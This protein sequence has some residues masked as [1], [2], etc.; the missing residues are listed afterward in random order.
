MNIGSPA[1]VS[2]S[3]VYAIETIGRGAAG[4]VY[5]VCWPSEFPLT[6]CGS[7]A[8]ESKASGIV[9]TQ[10]QDCEACARLVMGGMP[11]TRRNPH[12]R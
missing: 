3:M 6:L 2:E 9:N 12:R 4:R 10:G 5:H 11:R 8:T 7:L 1:I